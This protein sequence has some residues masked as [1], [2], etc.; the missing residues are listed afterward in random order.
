M[1]THPHMLS[2]CGEQGSVNSGVDNPE[3]N[4]ATLI[5]LSLHDG[6]RN[7]GCQP[8]ETVQGTLCSNQG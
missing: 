2:I 4:L 5:G 1:H 3:V 7:S 8:I 6:F